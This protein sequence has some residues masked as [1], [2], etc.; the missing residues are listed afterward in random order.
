MSKFT[1]PLSIAW[2]LLPLVL[3]PLIMKRGFVLITYLLLAGVLLGWFRGGL[4]QVEQQKLQKQFYH[5]VTISG[6]A[7]ED[8]VYADKSQQEFGMTNLVKNGQ[9][10]PGTVRVRGYGE[11]IIYR[12]DIVTVH[13]KMYP[14]RGSKQASISY[15]DVNVVARAQS[16]L[17]DFRRNFIVGMENALP[18][19]AASFG[20]GLLVGQRSLLSDE[21][22]LILVTVGLTHIVAVSGYNLTIIIRGTQKGLKRLSRFQIL[23]IS[24]TLIYLFL[25]ITGYSPSIVR[26]AIV[27]G[28]GLL[29]WYF[30]RAFRPIL[31]ILIAAVIVQIRTM[32]GVTLVSTCRS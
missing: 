1:E 20:V 26:A 5:T 12:H 13:G 7:T 17:E 27:A 19:P 16:T 18:E 28:L 2:L 29:A 11:A 3:S 30:G 10:L 23:S 8:S 15:A 22:S 4:L 9:K 21:L 31:L 14:A 25:L 6:R 24:L 32:Y